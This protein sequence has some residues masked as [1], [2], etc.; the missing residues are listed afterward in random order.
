MILFNQGNSLEIRQ[1]QPKDASI[2]IEAYKN[3]EFMRLYGSN[4]T[5]A[6]FSI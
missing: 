4:M 6:R 2:L 1:I 3:P 5:R